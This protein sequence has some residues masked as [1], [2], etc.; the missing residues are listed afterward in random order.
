MTC[1]RERGVT[2]SDAQLQSSSSEISTFDISLYN[3][4]RDELIKCI[5]LASERRFSYIVTPNVNHIVQ[6]DH[7]HELRHAYA[8]ASHRVCDSRVLQSLLNMMGRPVQEVIPGSDLTAAL[9]DIAE[10]RSWR[11]C[12]IG[13]SSDDVAKLQLTYPRVTFFHHDPPMGFI[14]KP[15]EIRACLDFVATN[16]A[17]LVVL[18]VGCPRQE[19]LA[20]KIFDDGRA[21]GVGLCVGASLNFLS[22][23]VKRAPQWMQRMSLE[24]LHRMC[25]EPG[26][27][28]RRYATDAV[29]VIPIILRNLR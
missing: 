21:K 16:P 11:V 18:S 6:L 28:V 2:G 19:L 22:G 25:M 23:K 26:R 8:A 24:W 7:D 5:S 14:S 9:M 29:R 10:C 4:S 20:R 15:A 12:I 27:L 1:D 17:H 3:R 13:C